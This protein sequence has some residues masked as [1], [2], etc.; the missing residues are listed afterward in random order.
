[1]DKSVAKAEISYYPLSL[2]R[3]ISNRKRNLLT[4]CCMF[5]RIGVCSLAPTSKFISFNEYI[6]TVS[7]LEQKLTDTFYKIF[8]TEYKVII[9]M[10]TYERLNNKTP[11]YVRR[12]VKSIIM[13]K[14]LKWELFVSAD[15]Y[16][17]ETILKMM[18]RTVPKSKL[19]LHNLDK[20]GERNNLSGTRL[21]L[22][23]SNSLE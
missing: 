21:V 18:F 15:N 13:Q 3:N 19:F 11:S 17:N 5:L 9:T 4:F 8:N 2:V 12:A 23:R 10:S 7:L 14:Y 20:P 22:R 1:M 6:H 16:L